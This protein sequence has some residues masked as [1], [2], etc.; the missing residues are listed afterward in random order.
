MSM[1]PVPVRPVDELQKVTRKVFCRSY[2]ECLN[3]ALSRGWAA[4]SCG[5][6]LDF[7]PAERPALDWIED[8][9]ACGT[10]L[11]VVFGLRIMRLMDFKGASRL[12]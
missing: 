4:F 11:D 5:S 9:L 2:A 3:L 1:T 8:A 10:L 12:A 6:C 7:D